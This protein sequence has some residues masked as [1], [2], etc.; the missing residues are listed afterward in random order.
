[1]WTNQADAYRVI[2]RLTKAAGIHTEIGNHTFRAIG[3][4]AYLL[5]GGTIEG[6]Q[7]IP[8]HNKAL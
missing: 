5:N 3:I 7:A 6:L 1:M 4:T 2:R 8:A